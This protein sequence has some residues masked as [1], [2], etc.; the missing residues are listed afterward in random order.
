MNK[1]KKS[2]EI[3]INREI[4]GK[5]LFLLLIRV[6]FPFLTIGSGFRDL[7]PAKHA[8]IAEFV[9]TGGTIKS[10]VSGDSFLLHRYE[11]GGT[12]HYHDATRWV[13]ALRNDSWCRMLPARLMLWE[14]LPRRSSCGI[15]NLPILPISGNSCYSW[16][17]SWHDSL[18]ITVIS[19]RISCPK[20]TWSKKDINSNR[21]F[22]CSHTPLSFF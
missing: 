7:P 3:K 8:F 19:W 12:G 1:N 16:V 6:F 11:A 17:I 13:Q 9:K 18:M 10:R 2:S 14:R 20:K 22:W 5:Y 4:S 21:R 15:T